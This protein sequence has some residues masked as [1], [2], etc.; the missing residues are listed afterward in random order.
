MLCNMEKYLIVIILSLIVGG[1]TSK[2]SNYSEANKFPNIFPDY[3]FVTIP[4][5]I[6]PLNFKL[7]G[8]TDKIFVSFK[9]KT[10]SV[11]IFGNQK[12][13]IPEKKWKNLLEKVKGDSITVTVFAKNSGKWIKYKPFQLYIGTSDIDP[14]L[15]YRLIA[16]GYENWSK[17]GI[18]Q[19][20]LTN[21]DQKAIIENSLTP[22]SCVNCH[23]FKQND[24]GNMMFHLRSPNGGTILIQD[25]KVQKLITKTDKTISNCI[26]PYWHP[27]GN[28]IAYSVNKIS[29]AFHAVKDKRIE[30]IDSESDLVVY[31]IKKNEIITCDL[32]SSKN[33]FETFPTFTPDGKSLI[34]SSAA[35]KKI[36]ESYNQIRY[37]LKRIAFNPENGAFGTTLETL[38][39]ADTLGKSISFPRVSPDGK[40]LMFTMADYGNFTIWHKEADLY[41]LNLENLKYYPLDNVNSDNTES[42]HSWSSNSRWFVFSSRRIDGLYTRPYIASIDENGKSGKPFLLPQK[43]PDYYTFLL[44]SFNI[45]ELIK[46][47]VEIDLTEIEKRSSVAGGKQVGFRK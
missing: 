23:S 46:G 38:I 28:Y 11:E 42:Y 1:C 32:L 17:M 10:C 24:P 40:F 18:Y 16:P 29:Q 39:N 15:A 27:S 30:V 22:G 3:Q 36:P 25:S 5:N 2:V 33:F 35:A 31:D 6:A 8:E 9:S 43:D 14:Y 13:C 12:I 41:L 37:N 44:E 47:P 4:S 34:F 26:Y 7:L 45:P 19:R 21:Y 20:N